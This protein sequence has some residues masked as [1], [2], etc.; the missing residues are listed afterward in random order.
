MFA[1]EDW[2]EDDGKDGK[3][4]TSRKRENKTIYI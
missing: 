2:C 1:R 3:S 4:V